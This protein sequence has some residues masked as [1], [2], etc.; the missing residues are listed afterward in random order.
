MK[1]C[2]H[3]KKTG[4]QAE[5]FVGIPKLKDKCLCMGCAIDIYL[6][7]RTINTQKKAITDKLPP[8]VND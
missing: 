2:F 8:L 4:N 5:K 1:K 6:I 7:I 3:C